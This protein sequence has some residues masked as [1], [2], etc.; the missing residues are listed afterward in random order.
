MKFRLLLNGSMKSLKENA[1]QSFRPVVDSG[2]QECLAPEIMTLRNL[3]SH[4]GAAENLAEQSIPVFCAQIIKL[5]IPNFSE[6]EFVTVY[7][8]VPY[9]IAGDWLPQVT[10]HPI[11]ATIVLALEMAALAFAIYGCTR[12][13]MDIRFRDWFVPDSSYLK[14]AVHIENDFFLGD[15]QPFSVYT[16]EPVDG[17]D[18]FNHQE[19]YLELIADLRKDSYVASIPPVVTW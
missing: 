5:I 3:Q 18:F 13:E 14:T 15:Q 11:G 10:L 6:S 1:A 2:D 9:R 19:A 17:Q 16:R 8:T 12:V 7:C 4:L